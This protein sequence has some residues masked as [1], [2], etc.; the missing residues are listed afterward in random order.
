MVS[1]LM[2]AWKYNTIVNNTWEIFFYST[3][4]LLLLALHKK[5]SK[6]IT[7]HFSNQYTIMYC[8]LHEVDEMLTYGLTYSTKLIA[9][10]FCIYINNKQ[11]STVL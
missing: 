10:L 5:K 4:A 1:T 2:A 8:L 11:V 9:V 3:L 6:S 7:T